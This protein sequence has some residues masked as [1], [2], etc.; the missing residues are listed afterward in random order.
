[1]HECNSPSKNRFEKLSNL[2]SINLG[3]CC[4]SVNEILSFLKNYSSYLTDLNLSTACVCRFI[5][6]HV[7][8]RANGCLIDFRFIEKSDVILSV[9]SYCTYPVNSFYFGVTLYLS[10][11]FFCF[12][13]SLCYARHNLLVHKYSLSSQIKTTLN[14]L[15]VHK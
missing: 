13:S 7:E 2:A 15:S 11:T 10:K 14:C 8:L 12:D 6:Q 1:M 9:S 4:E 5:Y 3:D